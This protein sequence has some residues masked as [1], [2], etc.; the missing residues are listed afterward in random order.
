MFDVREPT[1]F[2]LELHSKLELTQEPMRFVLARKA[3]S[4]ELQLLCL[5]FKDYKSIKA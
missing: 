4:V 2:I 5:L 1:G 3:G